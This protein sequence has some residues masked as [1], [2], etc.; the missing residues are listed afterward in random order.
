MNADY[1]G[2]E[3]TVLE[4]EQMTDDK[5]MRSLF[6]CSAIARNLVFPRRFSGCWAPTEEP[7]GPKPQMDAD[8]RRF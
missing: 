4:P 5:D 3:N 6:L 7:K 8:G 2:W 1:R